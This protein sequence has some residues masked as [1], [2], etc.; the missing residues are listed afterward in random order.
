MWNYNYNRILKN[1]C[2]HKYNMVFCKKRVDGK[3]LYIECCILCL[4]PNEKE[5]R[6][7]PGYGE[8]RAI[9]EFGVARVSNAP[10]FNS[11]LK[12]HPHERLIEFSKQMKN[13]D[14]EE[15]ITS[16]EWRS[17]RDQ[18][19]KID[20][21]KCQS[22]GKPAQQV[23]HL[24]YRRFKN[25]EM[26]DLISLCMDCHDKQHETSEIIKPDISAITS[27]FMGR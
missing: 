4:T 5:K 11:A 7:A 12:L 16:H 6:Y 24:S 8:K 22:C 25:E 21:N 9:K 3:F 17:K 10:L 15:Y 2:S 26:I 14:Y 18:R 13:I 1:T 23:H 19:L 27:K 20:N